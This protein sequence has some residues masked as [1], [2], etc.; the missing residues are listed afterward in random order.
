MSLIVTVD[1]MK[2]DFYESALS[3]YEMYVCWCRLNKSQKL[4]LQDRFGRDG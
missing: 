4:A 2:C 1:A 3:D